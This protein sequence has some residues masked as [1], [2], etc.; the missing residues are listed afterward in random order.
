[1]DNILEVKN[2]KTYFFKRR[3]IVKAVDEVSYGLEK[4][5]VLCL[6]GES[7]SGK[8]VSALSIVGLVERP[9][10]II[11]GEVLLKGEDL[12]KFS[13][14][15]VRSL[16]GGKIAMIFQNPRESLNPVFTIG[17]QIMEP[18]KAHLEISDEEAKKRT[19]QL[20]KRVGIESAEESVK[21][22]PHEFSGGMNQRA[23]IAIALCCDPEILIADEPTSALDVTTQAQFLE[24][25]MD[26][27][28]EREMSLIFIT[29]DL[30]IVAEIADKIVVMYAGKVMERG[31]VW[32]IFENPRHPYT[33]GLLGCLPDISVGHQREVTPIP[34][35]ISSLINPPS[36][37]VFHTRCKFAEE[38]CSK[39]VPPEAKVEE[40]HLS[41]CH[42][43][44]SKKVIDAKEVFRV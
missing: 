44:D 34:G 11:E 9:G 26:L 40:G 7:G 41:A 8:T 39:A 3:G 2:L 16:R 42:F 17:D 4:G 19:I 33:I 32:Q 37:C 23:M 30:G 35:V 28:R 31:S 5:E 21:S 43:W 10:R 27:K 1:M 29:H 18:M 13:P 15:K 38:I 6:V 24:L 25:L 12:R 20:L 14:E 36:G 22:Y